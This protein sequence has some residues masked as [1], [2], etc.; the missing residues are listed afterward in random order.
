MAKYRVYLDT[1][2]S[3]TVTVEVD[4][5]LDE[6]EAREAAIEKAFENA[7]S[8]SLCIH[9]TGYGQE[10]SRDLG[11]MEVSREADGSEIQPELVPE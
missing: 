9:C 4:D 5:E 6:Q 7:P 3:V 11:E 10:W 1:T 2:A 8:N